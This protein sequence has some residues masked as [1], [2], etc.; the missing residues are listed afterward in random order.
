MNINNRKKHIVIVKGGIGNQLFIYYFALYLKNKY[1]NDLVICE[2]RSYMWLD[3]K[4]GAKF[5]LENLG[6]KF[7]KNSLFGSFIM[8]FYFILI[9]L[10]PIDFINKILK[11]HLIINDKNL[12]ILDDLY[13]QK[14]K[15]IYNGYF[16]DYKIID[17]IYS[18]NKIS[19]K[20]YYLSNKYK[21]LENRIN[22]DI[23]SVAFCIRNF[24]MSDSARFNYPIKKFNDLIRL[25][26]KEKK[27]CK[28]YIFAFKNLNKKEYNFPENSEFITSENGY[29]D[30]K[31]VLKLITKCKIQV[32]S[33]SSTF[34]WMAAYISMSNNKDINKNNIYIS[35]NYGL[36]NKLIHPRWITF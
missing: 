35:E 8:A 14:K 19:F 9:N 22:K 17:S 10:L 36:K 29:S 1:P 7:Q 34:Y 12:K 5:K 30:D 23:N 27:D 16:Q 18:K 26:K 6:I 13:P 33:N 25:I 20:N 21:I 31:A 32:I 28:F 24:N 11:N 15:F 4:Y 3:I 2:T